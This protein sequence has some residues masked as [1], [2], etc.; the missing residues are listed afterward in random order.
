MKGMKTMLSNYLAVG[1]VLKPQ[2]VRGEVKVQ[3]L[4]NDPDRFFDLKE[5]Y[6]KQ[7]EAYVSQ[8][9]SCHRVHEGYAYLNF[10]GVED[11]DGAER[12]RG[13]VLYVDRAH[14]VP[15]GENENFICDLI[16]CEAF[17]REGN[18][19]GMLHDVMQPGANDVYVFQTPRGEMLLPALK[20][21]ILSVDVQKKRMVLDESALPRLAVYS[22]DSS[23]IC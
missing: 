18:P 20:E 5:V 8:S 7:G 13:A 4:T 9:V 6:I 3:P 10:E 12:L 23:S 11:R 17:D 19:V 1:E 15:L 2:G 14:A 16:G 22:D 21:V